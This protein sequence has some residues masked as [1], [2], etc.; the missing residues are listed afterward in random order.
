MKKAPPPADYLRAI[1][2]ALRIVDI[3]L[4]AAISMTAKASL[5]RAKERIRR[6]L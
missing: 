4:E 6:L 5:R 3:E 2:D 1:A